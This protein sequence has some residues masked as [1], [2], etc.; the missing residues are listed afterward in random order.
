M[1]V[2]AEDGVQ[3]R[4]DGLRCRDPHV[5]VDPENDHL[6]SPPAGAVDQGGVARAGGDLLLV[7]AGGRV[8]AG[9]EQLHAEP[10]GHVSDGVQGLGQVV[11]RLLGGAADPRHQF[12][13]IHEE[14]AGRPA[15]AQ[16]RGLPDACEQLFGE[17]A[18]FARRR[19][20][21]P[22]LPLDAEGPVRRG[23]EVHRHPFRPFSSAAPNGWTNRASPEPL[24]ER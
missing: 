14:F 3:Q 1:G 4:Q 2:V 6:S 21:D 12:D 23:P 22:Q 9:A 8:R 19:V 10:V 18:Q 17:R 16:L 15:R 24:P 7:P 13:G 5:D 20:D 11:R